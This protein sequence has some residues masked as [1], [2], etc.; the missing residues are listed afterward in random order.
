MADPT[1][2][3][4]TGLLTALRFIKDNRLLPHGFDKRTADKDVAVHGEAETDPNFVG[5]GNTIRYSVVVGGDESSFQVEAE[6]W[7]Q[8]IGYRWAMNLKP[9]DA[10]EPKRF[11]GYYEAMASGS[12]VM[13]VRTMAVTNH[14]ITAVAEGATSTARSP[15]RRAVPNR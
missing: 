15:V 8:P 3:P 7:Y 1:G 4:T 9:Y 12:A 5:G 2:R 14:Q 6:L 10:P 13:L 11:V